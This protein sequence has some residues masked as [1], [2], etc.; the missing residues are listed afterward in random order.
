MAISMPV[1]A[2][3]TTSFLCFPLF[4]GAPPPPPGMVPGVTTRISY[5]NNHD[6]PH[7]RACIAAFIAAVRAQISNGASTAGSELAGRSTSSMRRTRYLSTR[8][9]PHPHA[10]DPHSTESRFSVEAA[11]KR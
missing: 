7:R 1:V 8:A 9:H 2:S 4:Q 3:G 6:A 11:P 10:K 5:E